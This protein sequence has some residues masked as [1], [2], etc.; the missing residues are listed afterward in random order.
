MAN[1]KNEALAYALKEQDWDTPEDIERK[2][3]AR[4]LKLRSLDRK[5]IEREWKDRNP[6]DEL[7]QDDYGELLDI[8]LDLKLIKSK[9]ILK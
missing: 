3:K 9:P 2:N 7:G 4:Y 5:I 1:I 8:G 6:N